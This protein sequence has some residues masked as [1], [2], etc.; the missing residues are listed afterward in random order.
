MF[1]RSKY[2]QL[3][4]WKKNKPVFWGG[5]VT[6]LESYELTDW[7]SPEIYNA[8]VK[9]KDTIIRLWYLQLWE[10]LDW[11]WTYPRGI[12]WYISPDWTNN[13]LLVAYKKDTT[14]YLVKITEAWV[15]TPIA[16]AAL[17][18]VEARTSF[19]TVWG[20]TY[21]TNWTDIIWKYNWATYAVL[22]WTIPALFA[23]AFTVLFDGAIWASW[24]NTN[25]DTVYKTV[26]WNGDDYTWA[27]SDVFS[28]FGDNVVWL[29]VA[30]QSLFY[31]TNTTVWVTDKNDID[32]SSGVATY[33]QRPLV[34][35]EWAVNH[36]SIVAAWRYL[37]YI[38]P[39]NKI[40]MIIRSSEQF[41]AKD[42]SHREYDG[43]EEYMAKLDNDQTECFGYFLPFENI[44][45][46]H[47]KSKWSSY[48]NRPIVYDITHNCFLPDNQK[49]F[50][51][52]INFGNNYYTVSI[53]E[54]KVYRDEYSF[55]DDWTPIWFKKVSKEWVTWW[56]T[57]K[58]ELYQARRL[59]SYNR[60]AIVTE[61]I[62]MDGNLIQTETFDWTL[63]K[64]DDGIWTYPI[65]TSEIWVDGD[66]LWAE[67]EFFIS[68]WQQV[69]E[70]S[71]LSVR[72]YKIKIVW[73]CNTLWARLTLKDYD[74]RT[75]Q[76]NELVS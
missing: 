41:D 63:L 32:V 52:W 56:P 28:N 51:A 23:P 16:T 36:A 58:Q 4:K 70:K 15:Q 44:V 38:T 6:S 42:L 55:T 22:A 66:K 35:K 46:W 74:L 10:N 61:K 19:T 24:W 2:L 45:V 13:H 49:F 59:L 65:W 30:M 3:W 31:F 20:I 60:L 68:K 14:K 48:N 12:E 62:Y 33:N 40:K 71:M 64:N 47:F 1:N 27:W 53:L 69:T 7:D 25:P 72:W 8:R 57:F 50:Y 29:W 39:S 11:L 73:E 9:W 34:V 43:I 67:E 26:K 37:F 76:L 21:V 17:I 75:E 54:D 5:L 18:T